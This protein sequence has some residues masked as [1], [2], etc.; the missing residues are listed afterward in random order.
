MPATSTNNSDMTRFEYKSGS[1]GP[2]H[3]TTCLLLQC[4]S[5]NEFVLFVLLLFVLSFQIGSV[6]DQ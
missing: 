5:A 2:V 6:P 4:Q 3:I 1:T